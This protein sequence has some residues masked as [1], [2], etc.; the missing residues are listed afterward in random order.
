MD[1]IILKKNCLQELVMCSK[2]VKIKESNVG[3]NDI[4]MQLADYSKSTRVHIMVTNFVPNDYDN[5]I[6][7]IMNMYQ[8]QIGS[9]LFAFAK[10]TNLL[11]SNRELSDEYRYVFDR[12]LAER[13]LGNSLDRPSLMNKRI[14]KRKTEQEIEHLKS[15]S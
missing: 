15:G 9:S 10:W 13:S 14:F 4:T 5:M 3:A 8:T 1:N 12:A 2:I 6:N 7:K 11:M